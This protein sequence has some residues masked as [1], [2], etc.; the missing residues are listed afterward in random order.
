MKNKQNKKNQGMK[1]RFIHCFV[2]LN[3][4][5]KEEKMSL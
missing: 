5:V 4:K 3:F 1:R 2:K